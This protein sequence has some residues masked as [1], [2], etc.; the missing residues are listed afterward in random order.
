MNRINKLLIGAALAGACIAPVQAQHYGGSSYSHFGNHHSYSIGI[1]DAA[2]LIG[3]VGTL[4]HGGDYGYAPQVVY[5]P[6]QYPVYLPSVVPQPYPVYIPTPYQQHEVI[7]LPT[8]P[9][10]L[11]VPPPYPVYQQRVP[12]YQYQSRGGNY[13][14]RATGSNFCYQIQDHDKR[15]ECLAAS[16]NQA[17]YCTQIQGQD[18]RARCQAQVIIDNNRKDK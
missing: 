11:P 2:N 3:A 5:Q 17:S 8:G 4:I 13:E 12:P 14:V 10:F 7:Y 1:N 16:R 18:E 15:A 9:V 6:Y